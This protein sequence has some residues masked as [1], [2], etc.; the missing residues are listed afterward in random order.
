MLVLQVIDD[1]C[2]AGVDLV[3]FLL[4]LDIGVTRKAG[5]M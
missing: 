5:N 2:H 1:I 3:L 4:F